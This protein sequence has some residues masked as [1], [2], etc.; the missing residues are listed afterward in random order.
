MWSPNAD[1]RA[2]FFFFSTGALLGCS[3]SK[4]A[5]HG[6]DLQRNIE[7]V[8]SVKGRLHTGRTSGIFQG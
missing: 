7:P 4:H 8:T 6:A 2:A 1:V 5:I 3:Y